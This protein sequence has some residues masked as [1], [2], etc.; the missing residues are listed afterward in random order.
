VQDLVN[1]SNAIRERLS[2][3]VEVVFWEPGRSTFTHHSQ[4]KA[5]TCPLVWF[6][7]SGNN[8]GLQLSKQTVRS[9]SKADP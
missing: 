8:L 7:S 5:D 4:T 3:D 9:G 1:L 6:N 2:S